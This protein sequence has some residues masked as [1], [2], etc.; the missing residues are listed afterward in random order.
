MN[1]QENYPDVRLHFYEALLPDGWA[2]DVEVLIRGAEILSVNRD[3]PVS[4][5]VEC[6]ALGIPAMPNLHSHAFQRGFAGLAEYRNS[7]QDSFWTWRD[8]M[9]RFVERLTPEDIGAIAAQAY[10][11]MLEAGYCR[12]GEFH[13]LHNLPD[14]MRYDNPAEIAEQLVA[15]A[16]RS[17]IGLTLLPAFY[18]YGGF[19]CVPPGVAQRRFVSDLDSYA[20]LFEDCERAVCRIPGGNIGVAPHSL[21]AVSAPQLIALSAMAGPRPLHIHIAEQQKEVADC[22][23]FYGASPVQWLMDNAPVDEHWCLVHATHASADELRMVAACNAVIGL[24]P[25]TEANLGDGIFPAGHYL[26]SGGTFGIGTDSNIRITVSGEL[27]MLEYGQRLQQQA[28]NVLA[29]SDGSCARRVYEASLSGGMQVMDSKAGIAAGMPANIVTL[30][31]G[32]PALVARHGDAVLDGFVFSAGQNAIQD[33]WC[34][35]RKVVCCGRHIARDA[36]AA[37]YRRVITSLLSQ[38]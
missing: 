27:E 26:N 13:Y 18:A 17:G 15:A 35:G 33:V 6:Y 34:L 38:G 31:G 14:G 3:A 12:V 30:D 36:V 5:G 29:V 10:V 1:T 2:R 23:D 25:L 37:D 22:T 21:R 4:A 32:H 11:E 19:G 20:R 8:I 16:L 28:R 9:Y 24:C 7:V